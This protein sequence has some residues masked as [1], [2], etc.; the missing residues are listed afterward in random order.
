MIAFLDFEASG[1]CRGYPIE[2][3]WCS[4]DL[5]CGWSTL[6]RPTAAW[7]EHGI[8]DAEAQ[9]LHGLTQIGLG[10]R[11][12]MP[13]EVVARLEADLA[14]AEIAPESPEYDG[15]WMWQ[16]YEAAGK[17]PALRLDTRAE[18]L[19]TTAGK[20]LGDGGAVARMMVIGGLMPEEAGLQVHRALDDCLWL[21]LRLG[22]AAVVEAGRDHGEAVGAAL[23]AELVERA[24][25]IKAR[26]GRDY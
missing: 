2:V 20:A 8:W 1:L 13:A 14:G 4:H 10:Q 24:R 12:L 19:I 22:A 17:A 3:A 5:L 11:G 26:V 23:R 21:A 18:S 15:R 16:L 25:R 6:I 9:A 7:L